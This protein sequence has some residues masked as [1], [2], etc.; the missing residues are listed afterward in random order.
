MNVDETKSLEQIKQRCCIER[1]IKNDSPYYKNEQT[2]K[3]R[4]QQV[5]TRIWTKIEIIVNC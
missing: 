1:R 2:D 4:K 5:L 3:T